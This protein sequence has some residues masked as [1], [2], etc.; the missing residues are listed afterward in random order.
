[1]FLKDG[2]MSLH[3]LKNNFKFNLVSVKNYL[4]MTNKFRK[5]AC[6][7]NCARAAGLQLEVNR[8]RNTTN[9]LAFASCR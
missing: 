5:T 9:S 6:M 1:M 4:R 2:C 8:S 3:L 7:L